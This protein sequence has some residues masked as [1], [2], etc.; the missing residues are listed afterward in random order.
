[1]PVLAVGGVGIALLAAA[2]IA[3][4]LIWAKGPLVLLFNSTLGKL[5]LVGTYI[6]QYVTIGLD[7]LSA[8]VAGWAD[9]ALLGLGELVWAAGVGVWQIAYKVVQA[10]SGLRNSVIVLEEQAAADLSSAI[11]HANTLYSWSVGTAAADLSNARNYA[12]ALYN[13]THVY[14]DDIE[15]LVIT[16]ANGLFTQAVS[17]AQT[18]YNESIAY[19]TKVGNNLQ[20]NINAVEATATGGATAIVNSAIA[21]LQ[22]DVKAAESTLDAAVAAALATAGTIAAGAGSTA[23]QSLDQAAHDAVIGPWEALLPKLAPISTSIDQGVAGVLGFPG[24]LGEAVPVSIPGILALVVPAV[25]AI[26]TEVADCELGMCTNLSGLSGLLGDLTDTA[27]LAVLLA[28]LGEAVANPGGAVEDVVSGLGSLVD[29]TGQ[30][31]VS[32]VSAV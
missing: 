22:G 15:S 27:L 26:A 3:L 1:M 9:S 10:L 30:A 23:V 21:T 17:D 13:E 31:F 5:P 29:T 19:A 14:I 4:L 11:D 2:L 7:A 24:I 8:T 20:A 25:A 32:L 18:L 28:F 12:E 16:H 6:V